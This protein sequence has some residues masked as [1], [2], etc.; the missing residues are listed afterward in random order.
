MALFPTAEGGHGGDG[1]GGA[2]SE[3]IFVEEN[4]WVPVVRLG[5]RVS[6]FWPSYFGRCFMGDKLMSLVVHISWYSELVSTTPTRLDP[7]FATPA[8]FIKAIPAPDLY[9]VSQLL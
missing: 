6:L 7:I 5:G 9:I 3:V 2:R 8:C 1:G 4:K